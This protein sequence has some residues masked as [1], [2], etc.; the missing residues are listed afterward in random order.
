[1]RLKQQAIEQFRIESADLPATPQ[2]RKREDYLPA[3]R[4]RKG[5]ARE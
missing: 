4:R 3:L 5:E 2:Y 1:M